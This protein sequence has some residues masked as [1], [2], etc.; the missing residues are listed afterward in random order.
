[1]FC[2]LSGFVVVVFKK[3]GKYPLGKLVII[4]VTGFYLA[5]PIVRK[6]HDVELFT[7]SFDVL[8]GCD[9]GVLASLYG[10]L[11]SG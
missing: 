10:I 2:L 1:M 5:I 8:F 3:Q 6:S 11:F 7:E 4:G 9:G